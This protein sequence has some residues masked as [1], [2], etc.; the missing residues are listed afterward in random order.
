PEEQPARGDRSM[1]D[2]RRV[3]DDG[4]GALGVRAVRATIEGAVGLHAVADDLA[5]AVLTHGRELLDGA[6]ETVERVRLSG[7]HHLKRHLVV[8][9]AH[10]AYGH[11]RF[12]GRAMDR[13]VEIVWVSSL[14]RRRG[15]ATCVLDMRAR[16]RRTP[17]RSQWAGWGGA[18]PG[19]GNQACVLCAANC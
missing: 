14:V 18:L 16:R 13:T 4:F 17:A 6:L 12:L 11:G 19:P 15:R 10:F 9:A 3:I 8:V 7:G 5:A 2:V 1:G